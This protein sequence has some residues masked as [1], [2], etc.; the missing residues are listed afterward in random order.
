LDEGPVASTLSIARRTL[1]D[2]DLTDFEMEV[3]VRQVIDLGKQTPVHAIGNV[4]NAIL[5]A[6][7]FWHRLPHLPVA[8]WIG[9]FVAFSL[10]EVVRW[11]RKRH[12]ATPIRVSR[13]AISRTTLWAFFAGLMWA[14]AMIYV[15]PRDDLPLQLLILFLA[16]GLGAGAVASMAAQPFAC[17]AYLVPPL[18]ATLA[19]I[20]TEEG[21]IAHVI[22]AMGLLYVGA[23][24]VVLVGGFSSFVTIIRTR[25]DSRDLATQLL[26]SQLAASTEANRAKSQFL[27]N[28]SHELR[29]PLNAVIGFSEL[30]RDQSLGHDAIDQYCEYA[31][32][33]HSAGQHLLRIV[34]DLLDISKI[35]AGR[36]ALQE[37]EMEIAPAVAAARKMVLQAAAD[38]GVDIAVNLPS[39][40]PTLRADEARVRQILLNLLSNAVKFS[41]R[42][43]HVKIGAALRADGD[44][45]ISISD[46]GI[47]MS[48][49]EIETA[50]K[51]FSQI[52]ASLSRRNE[53]LGLGLPLVNAFVELHGGRFELTSKPAVGTTATVIFPSVRVMAHHAA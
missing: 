6:W 41:H 7:V 4:G 29:T 39:N 14:G 19:L 28:M 22:T 21:Y 8:I 32:D 44:L 46:T 31:S 2:D 5:L 53:G 47:G 15:F 18:G 11:Q 12:W 42:A 40:L 13:R 3:R 49:E 36:L 27:T 48:A 52:D 34:D 30:I 16:G 20:G 17:M 45:A 51:P 43:G 24:L 1:F 9:L 33:I 10:L 25:I 26:E 50:M 23:L 38:I 35:E 37:G